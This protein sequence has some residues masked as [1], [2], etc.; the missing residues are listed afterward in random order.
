M[1]RLAIV[2][3]LMAVACGRPQAQTG[4]SPVA[5]TP[6]PSATATVVA[7]PS[8]SASPITSPKPSPLPQPS[9]SKSLLFAVLEAKNTVAIA[10]LDGYAR[11]KTTF[12]PMPV[13]D[14]GCMGANVPQSAEVAAGKVY[15]ADGAGVVRSLA[16]NGQVTRVASFPFSGHQ[17]MLSFAVSPDGSRLLAAV[18]TVPVK[19]FPCGGAPKQPLTLDVYSARPGAPSTL[20]YHENVPNTST[21][22]SV[23]KLVGWDNVGPLGTYPTDWADQGGGPRPWFFGIPVRV[24]ASTGKVIRQVGD[25]NSCLVWDM[26]FTGASV[27][28]QD[29]LLNASGTYDQ[30][31]K[32]RRMDGAELWHFTVSLGPLGL[33]DP[34]FENDVISPFLAPDEQHVVLCCAVVGGNYGDDTVVARDGGQVILG[35]NFYAEGWLDSTTVIGSASSPP[36]LLSYVSLSAPN[37]VVSMGFSGQVLGT[38][39]P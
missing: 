7:S 26:V 34:N 32:V 1:R 19:F 28:V 6:S 24:D 33:D 31:L 8:P 25:Q 9:T 11:A 35:T 22:L 4:T 39:R 17:Q 29:R 5:E 3:L 2:L 21:G 37:R 23:L 10:G 27:C 12:I 30:I 20:L 13:P 36:Y 18:L 14:V 16:V 15:F 38:V